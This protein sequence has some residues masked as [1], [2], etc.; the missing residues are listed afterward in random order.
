LCSAQNEGECAGPASQL[1]VIY[2]R[3]R[4]AFTSPSLSS[5]N[6]HVRPELRGLPTYDHYATGTALDTGAALVADAGLGKGVPLCPEPPPHIGQPSSNA[7]PV[8][9][10]SKLPSSNPAKTQPSL[11]AG[12]QWQ[13]APTWTAQRT[14][15]VKASQLGGSD[16]VPPPWVGLLAR[17]KAVRP[18]GNR[19]LPGGPRWCH[20]ESLPQPRAGSPENAKPG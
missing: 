11:T 4:A 13:G 16:G 9:K 18:S 15:P 5:R 12:C 17:T 3:A 2:P 7:S 1:S 14:L 10:P 19:W 20:K 8:A 6:I